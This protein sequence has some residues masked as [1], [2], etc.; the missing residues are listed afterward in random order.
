MR[1]RGSCRRARK[2]RFEVE[3]DDQQVLLERAPAR[4]QLAA[5]VEDQAVAVE[6]ELVLAADQVD[7]ADDDGVVGRARREHAL[8]EAR[9]PAWYGEPLMLTMTSAPASACAC[10]RAL[11]VPDVLADVHAERR[12]AAIAKTGVSV[13]GLE[14]ALLVEDAV[15]R[16]EL[17]VVD[18]G[19]LAVVDHRGGVVD[20]V[21]R[22][23][24]ADDRR[25][26]R[27]RRAATSSSARRLSSMNAGEQEVLGRVAGERQL[28]KGDELGAQVARALDRVDD[29]A[30]LPSRSPTVVLICARATRNR[31]MAPIVPGPPGHL[32]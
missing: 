3:V 15:V 8:A 7:V 21:A 14:V 2:T 4:E 9:L 23:D 31:L 13:P 28:R 32:L 20:V 10:G 6:D 19:A 12:V 24:E 16:Q 26:A 18:A 22:V 5:L 27:A 29:R 25:D 1:R 11:R 30:T 17:L